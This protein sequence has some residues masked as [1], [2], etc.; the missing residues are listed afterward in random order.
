MSSN[1]IQL[2]IELGRQLYDLIFGL[3]LVLSFSLGLISGGQR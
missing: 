3:G 2:L 1:E